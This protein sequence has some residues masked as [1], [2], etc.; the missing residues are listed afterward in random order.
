MSLFAAH[1][2]PLHSPPSWRGWNLSLTP[3]RMTNVGTRKSS[4][5]PLQWRW[6]LHDS[7]LVTALFECPRM[8]GNLRLLPQACAQNFRRAKKADPW[9]AARICRGCEI[10][11]GHA[12]EQFPDALEDVRQC[13]F[14]GRKDQRL[15]AGLVCISEFNRLSELMRGRFRRDNPPGLGARLRCYRIIIEEGDAQ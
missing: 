6:G 4:Q 13:V 1:Y 3:P 9:D 2:L 10:G 5:S 11:A 12:G 15:V 7:A 14:C 8:T